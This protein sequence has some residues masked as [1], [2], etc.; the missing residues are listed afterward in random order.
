MKKL[1]ITED[2]KKHI[3]NL[4]GLLTEAIDPNSG[5][6]TTINNYYPSGWYTLGNKDTQ[7][8]KIIQNQLDEILAPPPSAINCSKVVSI[9]F[10]AD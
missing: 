10:C 1:L 5:G 4:Y 7:S 3:L 2:D 8:G 9:P 6:T